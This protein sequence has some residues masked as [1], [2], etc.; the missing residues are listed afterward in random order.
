MK[1]LLISALLVLLPSQSWAERL[2]TSGFET[3]NFTA[4]EW[5][6][7]SGT[8]PTIVTSGPAPHSGTYCMKATT[9][10]AVGNIALDLQ[11]NI[12]SGHVYGRFYFNI[13][14][15]PN[16]VVDFW[17]FRSSVAV[18][19]IS[20]RYVNTTNVL[21]L[22]N[23]IAATD[24]DFTTTLST[25][26]WYRVE[27]DVTLSDTVGTA[28]A[29]LFVG[30]ATV[31]T[32]S[33]TNASVDTLPTNF[34]RIAVGLFT[35]NSTGTVA[36]D[37]IAVNTSAAGVQTSYPGPGK[38]AMVK[39]ASNDTV[40]WTKTGAN[41]SGTNNFDCTD[42]E[43]GVPDD[44]SGYIRSTTAGQIDRFN[45]TGLPAEVTSDATMILMH[46]RGR[47]GGTSTT[48]TPTARYKIWNDA[49]TITNGATQA[50]CDTT[51]WATVALNN[52]ASPVVSLTGKSKATVNT[53]DIGAEVVAATA[54]GCNT[55]SLWS[56]VEW[57]E[58]PAVT[59]STF[60]AL[61]GVGCK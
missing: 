31:E 37:D 48:G 55:T 16:A 39:A 8:A 61:I 29:K 34:G 1:K 25:S 51:T 60:I 20:V 7:T 9:A 28:T 17:S 30:D 23:N 43:P 5:T 6:S 4:T 22:R 15:A 45:D 59:C 11:T 27:I 13:Q 2:I 36:F 12:T 24:T 40:T 18:D 10:A 32:E 58:T 35:T 53:Y 42:D 44:L 56:N 33:K 14:T 54:G 21:R 38:I 47:T 41:C 57:L 50:V 49:S 19:G 3:N 46:L 52:A 26:T